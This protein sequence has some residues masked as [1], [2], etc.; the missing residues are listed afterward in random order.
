MAAAAAAAVMENAARMAAPFV[1]V[2]DMDES[3]SAGRV[4][5]WRLCGDQL[6]IAGGC[7]E[8]AVPDSRRV[9]NA[10]VKCT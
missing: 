8:Q 9:G 4:V 2:R 5:A 3:C 10:V 7:S 6:E 1:G